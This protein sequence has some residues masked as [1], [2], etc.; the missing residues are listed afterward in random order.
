MVEA[1]LT[2]RGLVRYGIDAVQQSDLT[3]HFE[4][5]IGWHRFFIIVSGT[6]L[7][8]PS[9]LFQANSS[10]LDFFM[11]KNIMHIGMNA[12]FCTK[13]T[14]TVSPMAKA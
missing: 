11:G 4:P 6:V 7:L 8:D 14:T 9:S 2:G 5:R 1:E 3:I 12:T 13:A 10:Y